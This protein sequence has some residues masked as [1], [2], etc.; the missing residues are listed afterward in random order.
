MRQRRKLI[1][2]LQ[3]EHLRAQL[4]Q[5][6]WQLQQQRRRRLRGEC[7][8]QHEPLWKLRRRVRQRQQWDEQL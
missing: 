4:Q 6:L 1:S 7:F 3:R 5:R 2:D 8:E